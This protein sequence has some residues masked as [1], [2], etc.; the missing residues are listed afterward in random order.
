MPGPEPSTTL[1]ICAGSLPTQ[2]DCVPLMLLALTLT[3]PITAVLFEEIVLEQMVLPLP[4]EIFVIVMFVLPPLAR[5]P[6][7]KDAVP[8]ELT[9]NDAVIPVP[10]FAPERL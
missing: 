3:T 2:R 5:T 10:E 9:V 6:V 7:L 4:D 8:A 1:L